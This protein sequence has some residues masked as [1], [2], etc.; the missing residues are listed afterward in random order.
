[1]L[2]PLF[3]AAQATGF[4]VVDA[5]IADTQKA[6]QSGEIT[7]KG[8][9]Q[10]YI[11]RIKAYNGT[12]TALVT[13]D[14]AAVNTGPGRVI[15]GKAMTYPTQ[16]VAASKFLPDLD[17]YQGPPIEFGRMEPTVSNPAIQQQ[18][19]MRVGIPG[20]KGVNAVETLNIRGERSV[21]CKGRFDAHPS[22]G[23]LPKDAP[24]ECEKFRQQ[25]DALE[26]AA[27][28]DKQYGTHPDLEAMPM[29]CVAFAWKSWY[30]ATDIRGTGGQDV[31]FAMDAPKYDSPDVAQLRA[32]GAVSLAVLN[33]ARATAGGDGPEKAKS[34]FIGNNLAYGA[35]GGQPCNPY[36]TERVPRGS[37]SGSGVAVSANL[38][39]CSIC[40]Q[41]GGSCKGPA[42]RNNIVNLLTTKGILMD[43]GYGYQKI[44]DRAGIHCRT[45]ADAVK[46][47]DAAKGF[48]PKDIYSALPTGT[49]PKAAYTSFLVDDAGAAAR[50]LKGMRIALAR[51]FMVKH[52]K[53]DAAISDQMDKEIKAV[54]RDKLGAELVETVDPKYPDDPTVPNVKYTFED[55]FKEILPSLAPEY[56]WQKKAD[57]SL[58]FAVPGWD[59]TSV[60]YQV[61]LATGK[62]PL[63]PAL[64]LRRSF[65]SA[66]Q[67]EGTLGWDKYLA[68]RGDARVKT[69]ADWVANA[70]FDTEAMRASA[71]NAANTTDP[72]VE[73]GDISYVK[74]QT[75]LRMVILK[76]MQQ[77]G[78]D[79]F[80]NP[81]NT[82][83]PFKLGQASEPAVDNREANGY[84]MAFTA[85]AGTPE[86]EVP[87]GY[88]DIVY[89]P[90]YV[91]SSDR[92]K[93]VPVTGS[94]ASTLPTP[95]P[96]SLA[97]WGG[98]GDES[99]LIKVASA[100]ESATHHRKP[101]PAFGPLAS[102]K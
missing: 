80:V 40:E 96:V 11:D 47:L 7:C 27:E 6:I 69:W 66:A 79:A 41:T 77:N 16:T 61:A 31:N 83:P 15:G 22:T 21:T 37:S 78:I 53:N 87:A 35:Y 12:C 74:M 45:V 90:G 14:G 2:A 26:H 46:V 93:Y 70:K 42:S 97:I 56:F 89:E 43:G 48:D 5:T 4:Q 19:G 73:A 100:Y 81:E 76:V 92:T 8:V 20:A 38:A 36:D 86:I 91:L 59:V 39:A 32:K 28:L 75:V 30:D 57:G 25:P 101:P 49:I 102:K 64:N 24:A 71:V 68:E 67:Y 1:V 65:K 13:R 23:P 54:L 17:K 51:E 18:W 95:M 55:A 94:V 62:A 52:T 34:V 88:S 82:L 44:G 10:Q 84:G 72:R 58:E 50:P 33:A 3:G 99:V 98:P 29:Y 63:S 60:K 9:V 85:M